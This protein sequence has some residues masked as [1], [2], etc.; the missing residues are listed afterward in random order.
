M[1]LS[2]IEETTAK[3]EYVYTNDTGD[4]KIYNKF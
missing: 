3:T 1:S 2:I 4:A